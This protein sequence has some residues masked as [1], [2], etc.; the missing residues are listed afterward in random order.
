MT[1]S[2]IPSELR[3]DVDYVV[4]EISSTDTLD[5]IWEVVMITT[6]VG[7][8]RSFQTTLGYSEYP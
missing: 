7:S 2:D 3:T 1:T 8:G 5:M 4:T 6:M